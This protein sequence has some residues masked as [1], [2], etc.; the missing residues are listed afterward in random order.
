MRGLPAASVDVGRYLEHLVE[1]EGR[2]LATARLC[3]AASA[4]GHRLKR[5]LESAA[6]SLPTL[7]L[8]APPDR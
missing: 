3:L 4:G 5:S 8:K 6:L 2:T 7:P 1:T